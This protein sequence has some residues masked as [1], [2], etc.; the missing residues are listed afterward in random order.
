MADLFEAE[1]EARRGAAQPLAAR[2]RPRSLDEVVG[3]EDL[4]A[5]GA[6]FRTVV[7]SGRL[8][9]TRTDHIHC[10]AGHFR[11]CVRGAAKSS[12]RTTLA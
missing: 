3:Q 5:T 12:R 11:Q 9:F 1:R 8:D 2:M 6:A 10:P 7:E 4:V